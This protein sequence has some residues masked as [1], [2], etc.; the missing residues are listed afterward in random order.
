MVQHFWKQHR[1]Y[2]QEVLMRVLSRHQTALK[3]RARV[4]VNIERLAKEPQECLNG[5][6]EWAESKVPGPRVQTSKGTVASKD[7]KRP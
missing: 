7:R 3:R 2:R 4:T 6:S 1:G 5:K